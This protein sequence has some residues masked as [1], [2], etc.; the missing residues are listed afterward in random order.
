MNKK[1]S[2]SA[3]LLSM[4]ILGTAIPLVIFG[5]ITIWQGMLSERTAKVESGK[6]AYGDLDHIVD[7]VYGMVISQQEVLQQK[8]N[9]DLK[10]AA[11][12]LSA[13]GG[14]R[15]GQEKVSWAAKNQLSSVSQSVSL[16]QMLV[17]TQAVV[18]NADVK[19]S[20]PLVDKVKSL[21]GGTCTV[22]QKM[23]DSG[24]MLRVLTNVETKDCKRAIG[25]YIPAIEPDGKPN[26]VIQAVMKGEKYLGRAFV[27]N[28]WYITA[29][30][31]LKSADGKI[32]GMLFV[33]VPENSALTL[34][35]QILKTKVGKT[36]YVYVIDTKGTYIISQGGKRDGEVIWESKDADGNLF[37]QSIVKKAL[38]TQPGQAFEEIYPWKN[39]GDLRP[40]MKTVRFKY[41]PDWDWIIGAGTWDEEFHAADMAIQTTNRHGNMIMAAVFIA[42]LVITAL[43]WILVSRNL[44]RTLNGIIGGLSSG[45]EQVTAASGQVASASQSLAQGA[46]EQ[47]SS[48]EETSASLE[49]MS[50]MTRQNA[51]NANQANTVARQASE[52]A[53]TG[54]ES[55]KKMQDAIDKIKNSASETAKIIKTIDE[56]A[57][58][59]NLLALN[60]AVEAARAGEAGKGFAVV[61]EEVRNL[62]RRSAEAAKNTADLIEGAQK[63]ADAGVSVTAEVA[64]NLSGIKENSG[65]VATLIAEIAAASKEQAQGIDQVNTAVSEMDKVVQQNAANAEESSS[66]AEELSSQAQELNSMVADL[67]GIVTGR[68]NV[69]TQTLIGAGNAGVKSRF[70]SVSDRSCAPQKG[71][72]NKMLA[73]SH[74]E[75]ARETTSR[76]AKP[77]KPET[78]IP[79]DDDEL[80]KF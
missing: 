68:S 25:T 41:F 78:I 21:V 13:A 72:V 75:N 26:V 14:I 61:A 73:A 63:N 47:A 62:A 51:D 30:E 9:S 66:A 45:S 12:E 59:T 77:L 39:Q 79:L 46:S 36:G 7:G 80:K 67:T 33:G 20:S 71:K 11:N 49:E 52:L 37:I 3:K 70:D 57:F 55:M 17:G 38:A 58:Q 60:A 48:L 5:V 64:K 53:E 27:V 42:C 56:I 50:S 18:P 1:W 2:L 44:G 19:V 15:M 24:D 40:R 28:A 69:E 8:V 34:R 65:K 35:E 4:G 54:V 76:Q 74:G 31:P 23:N 29:Y 32:I 16:N 43:M 10:V 6:L 22:F